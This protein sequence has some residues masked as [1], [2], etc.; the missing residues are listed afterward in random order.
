M[1][2]KLP[3]HCQTLPGRPPGIL[4]PGD[5]WGS[6]TRDQIETEKGNR[7]YSQQCS[8]LG[9]LFPFAE[10]PKQR[11]QTVALP[12]YEIGR[13]EGHTETI[14]KEIASSRAVG[15]KEQS[16]GKQFGV[17]KAGGG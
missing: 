10:V 3:Q 1:D 6:T 17:S 14:H 13:R 2:N 7:A 11:S 12:D 9:R 5:H 15:N 8:G 4:P 16:C